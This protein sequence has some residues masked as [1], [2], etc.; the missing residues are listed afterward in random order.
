ML[1]AY[2]MINVILVSWRAQSNPRA[3]MTFLYCVRYPI[4]HLPMI[5]I[6][7]GVLLVVSPKGNPQWGC[8]VK[9]PEQWWMPVEML[10]YRHL[11][12]QPEYQEVWGKSH[13]DEIGRLAQGMKGRVIGINTMFFINKNEVPSDRFKDAKYGRMCCNHR[14]GKA[15]PN[16]A[17]L[18]VGGNKCN[19]NCN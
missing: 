2:S 5:W 11:I 7:V 13:G 4:G 15:E 12:R 19:F 1:P 18:K 8:C 17:R 3:L 16:R 10:E 14:E 9:W 6:V